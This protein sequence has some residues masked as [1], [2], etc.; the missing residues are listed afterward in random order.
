MTFRDDVLAAG[1]LRPGGS[2]GVYARSAD[3]EAVVAGISALVAAAS[4]ESPTVLRFPPIEARADFVRTGYLASFPD[5]VGSVHTFR[6]DDRDH[7]ALLATCAEGGDWTAALVP[8]DV[9]LCSAACHPLF[10]L[11]TGVL[12]EPA[13]YDVCGWVFRAEP[14]VDLARMQA[15]HQHEMVYVGTPDGALAHRDTWLE[16]GEDLLR[17]LGL[18]VERVVAN[19]P[20][21]GRAGRIMS[22]GQ[23]DEELKYEL[24]CEVGSAENPTAI[25]SSN[26]HRDHFGAD[27]GISLAGEP[28]HSACV[29]FGLERIALALIRHHGTDLRS[30]PV[31]ERL[32]LSPR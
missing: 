6:G 16:R 25:T 15:F 22:A 4:Q 30:W 8:A 18:P 32:G 27:F 5:L 2:E 1:W 13:V 11:L 26:L 7:A 10:P 20:F 28:A 14:S 19:D 21:F 24:V 3:F 12:E 31:R 17:S 9:T 29:G 23:R